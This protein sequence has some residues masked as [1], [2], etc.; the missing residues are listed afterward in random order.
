MTSLFS[1]GGD[2]EVFAG[3]HSMSGFKALL[4]VFAGDLDLVIDGDDED[5]LLLAGDL[6]VGDSF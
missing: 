4:D 6:K 1:A 3:A 2:D 5:A